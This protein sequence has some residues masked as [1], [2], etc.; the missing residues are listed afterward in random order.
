MGQRIAIVNCCV[1]AWVRSAS[2]PRGLF[3]GSFSNERDQLELLIQ[4]SFAE[5]DEGELPE[6]TYLVA[7][8]LMTG[9]VVWRAG[10]LAVMVSPGYLA[11]G[12]SCLDHPHVTE[13]ICSWLA[14]V[15]EMSNYSASKQRPGWF[16][17]EQLLASSGRDIELDSVRKCWTAPV[18]CAWV[19]G[20]LPDDD[21]LGD[22]CRSD[23]AAN[24]LVVTLACPRPQ[25]GGHG[26]ELRCA[27]PGVQH[28]RTLGPRTAADRR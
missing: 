25:R 4:S 9:Q 22:S 12:P 11:R 27:E 5:T 17:W 13:K 24:R 14:N 1:P 18:S 21:G 8:D 3:A 10:G 6:A 16:R 15:M 7:R 26:I 23:Y 28:Q 2:I 19:S 20:D